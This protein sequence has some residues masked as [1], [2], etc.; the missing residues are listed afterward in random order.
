MEGARAFSLVSFISKSRVLTTGAPENSPKGES[1]K[2]Q[3]CLEVELDL[4]LKIWP[5]CKLHFLKDSSKICVEW[6][7]INSILWL[8]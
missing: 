1:L 4:E 2:M 8:Y 6:Y 7:L 5:R 3:H